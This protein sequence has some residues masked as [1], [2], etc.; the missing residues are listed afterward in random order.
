MYGGTPLQFRQ[1]MTL[2]RQ[3]KLGV[4]DWVKV[5]VE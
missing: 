5:P 3:A 1:V 4:S 2:V